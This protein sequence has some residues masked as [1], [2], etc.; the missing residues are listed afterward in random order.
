MSEI[1][2]DHNKHGIQLRKSASTSDCAVIEL[3]KNGVLHR[4]ELHRQFNFACLNSIYNEKMLC[5]VVLVAQGSEIHAHKV[6][7]ATC[8]P[9]FYWKFSDDRKLGQ[10]NRIVMEN[11][12]FETLSAIVNYLYTSEIF[13]TEN[14]VEDL[15][16]AAC[17]WV[18]KDLQQACHDFLKTNLN[19]SNC[20]Q[21]RDIANHF[22]CNEL[23][24]KLDNYIGMNL[25]EIV[26]RQEFLGLTCDQLT[27][28]ISSDQLSSTEESILECVF[29]WVRHDLESRRHLFYR[30]MKGIRFR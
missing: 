27:R 8:S 24:P 11:I 3:N 17:I 29:K 2:Q 15:L 19:L 5:D 28:V 21:Y 10:L 30:L 26:A 12:A 25:S 18:L 14:N 1:L 16:A 7:L 9:I 4:N 20:L 13:I 23:I 22:K 6:V